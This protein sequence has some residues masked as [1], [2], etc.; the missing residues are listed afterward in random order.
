[1]DNHPLKILVDQCITIIIDAITA[2][3]IGGRRPRCA[4]VLESPFN[5]E[6][7]PPR[8]TSAHATLG[9]VAKKVFI[10]AAITI[11]IS[12]VAAGVPLG[13]EPGCAAVLHLTLDTEG[14]AQ[15]MT[16]SPPTL[17]LLAREAL[18]KA[19]I[20]VI[21]DGITGHIV[22][23]RLSRNAAVYDL[24][25]DTLGLACRSTGAHTTAGLLA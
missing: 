19:A 16:L 24:R 21:V 12:T 17:R 11:I 5:T 18:I 3:I 14:A 10:K 25:V 23:S 6:D 20:A 8:C 4:A 13:R 2:D 7:L 15:S 9:G 1:L 22:K